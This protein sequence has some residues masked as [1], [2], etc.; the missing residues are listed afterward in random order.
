[1]TFR[2]TQTERNSPETSSRS[3]TFCQDQDAVHA[4]PANARVLQG[5]KLGVFP[6]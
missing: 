4:S 5:F 1:M 3:D 2:D 6:L